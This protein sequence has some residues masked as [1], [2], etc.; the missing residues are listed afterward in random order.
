[1]T[2]GSR[3]PVIEAV[4]LAFLV[5]SS[6][7]TVL[8]IYCRGWVIKAFALDDW[9]AV[10]AQVLFVVFC[11]YEVKGVQY[12]A[13]QH[14]MMISAEIRP[15]AM[16]MWWTCEPLYALTGMAIKASIAIFLLRICV[17]RSH[18]IIILAVTAITE[19]YSAIFF[20]LFI[21]QCQPVSLFWQRFGAD[22]PAGHCNDARIISDVFYG[23]SAISCLTDWTYS[24]LPIF[25]VVK[26]QMSTRLKVSVALILASGAIAST[27]TIVRFPYLYSL[28][29]TDDFLY[30]VSDVAI[31]TTVEIG[32]AI[33]AANVATLRPLLR[34]IFGGGSSGGRGKSGGDTTT[35]ARPW[36]RT[37]SGNHSKGGT[38]IEAF[39][40]H[41]R[42]N[43]NMG[44]TTIIDNGND[45]DAEAQRG[46][47][48]RHR[49]DDTKSLGSSSTA[50]SREDWN[51]SQSE[52]ARDAVG[53]PSGAPGSASGAAGGSRWNIMVKQSIVQT[54]S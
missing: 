21:V 47:R 25:I 39:D 40:L 29:D 6:I 53:S 12:G 16:R 7:A 50:E 15:E 20:I 41:D 10:A 51:N 5:I 13:G 52:L 35:A 34:P 42:T 28:T 22:P 19:V 45:V 9:L 48:N 2:S 8:R 43:G 46:R 54:R 14:V 38:R 31:W 36:Y 11:A 49:G 44:T 3:G 18:K 30:S 32:I 27:A 33:T 24:I 4:T 37:G 1:M 23:Y 26:L 17:E